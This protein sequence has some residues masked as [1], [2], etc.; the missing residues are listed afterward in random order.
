M[1]KVEAG[2]ARAKARPGDKGA[3][4]VSR[5]SVLPKILF[6]VQ[7]SARFARRID[8]PSG[9][10]SA[11]GSK[12]ES[13]E[14]LPCMWA[15]CTLSYVGAKRLSADVIRKFGEGILAQASSSSTD[16]GLKLRGPSQSSP[17]VA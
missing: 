9:K 2:L 11:S 5:G 16:W 7:G 6:D 1:K 13:T 10:V 14:D 12:P 8:L 4:L 3:H 15:C 17:R